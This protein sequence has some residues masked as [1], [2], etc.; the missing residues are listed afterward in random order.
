[1]QR[2]AL[3]HITVVD[4]DPIALA[5]AARGAG[6]DGICL[7][8]EPMAVLPLMPRFDL[9]G[10]R[11]ARK[12][13]KARMDDLGIA[14]DVAYPFTLAGRTTVSDFAPAM[15]C[16]AELGAGVLNV[17]LY[18]RDAQRR[19]DTLAAFG[20]LAAGH[21]LRVGVEFYPSSQVRSLAEALALVEAA[22]P[23]ERVAINVDLLHLMRSGGT[24]AELAAAPAERICYG[25]ISDAPLA[26]PADPDLEASSQ[27]LLPGEGQFDVAGFVRAL[28]P[29]CLLS[30]EIP[31]D[32]AVRASVSLAERAEQAVGSVRRA[33]A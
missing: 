11:A 29:G 3:D 27:R 28:P 16:A 6:C 4:A 14:L 32:D 20:E 21:G 10:D 31:R 33:L 5:E 9:Y 25:Q 1:M 7:F 18:D 26:A 23:P 30:V 12:A 22:G 13:L 19:L 15:D 17:L 2:L 8:M 24:L